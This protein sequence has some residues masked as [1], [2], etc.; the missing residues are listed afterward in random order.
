MALSE[1]EKLE[2]RYQENPQGLTFAPLAEAYR[3]SGD[4]QRAIDVLTPGLE[5]HPDYIP[6]SIVLGRCQL[7]LK[8][9][10]AAEAA[11]AHV[12][13]L[14]SENVIALKALADITE[15]GA[16]FGD[17]SR[18]LEQLL[19]VDRSNEEAREQLERVRASQSQQAVADEGAAAPGSADAGDAG[20]VAPLDGLEQT[21]VGEGAVEDDEF[22]ETLPPL[23]TVERETSGAAAVE[24][25][26]VEAFEPTA[27]AAPEPPPYS[28]PVADPSAVVLE[29]D[30]GVMQLGTSEEIVLSAAE[31]TEFQLP[32]ASEA[33]SADAVPD[34]SRSEASEYQLPSASEDMGGVPSAGAATGGS[35]YQL[36]SASEELVPE[37]DIASGASEFQLPDASSDFGGSALSMGDPSVASNEYQSADASAELLSPSLSADPVEEARA[38]EPAESLPPAVAAVFDADSDEDVEPGEWVT[39]SDAALDAGAAPFEQEVEA[40]EVSGS[41][42][43]TEVMEIVS[44][45]GDP[46]PPEAAAGPASEIAEPEMAA[47]AVGEPEVLAAGFV[48][49]EITETIAVVEPADVA[50]PDLVVT[51]SMAELFLKQ[52]HP[53][54]ALR[55][56]QELLSRRPDDTRLTDLVASLVASAPADEVLPPYAAS[57]S[58]GTSV[59]E[60]MRTV[61]GSR[62]NGLASAPP[63]VPANATGAPGTPTR[64]AGDHLTLSAIFGE[65][66]APMPPMSRKPRAASGPTAGRGGVSFDEFYGGGPAQ[67][68][69]TTR[70]A[71]ASHGAGGEDDLDQFHDWLQNLKR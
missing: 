30:L 61:L 52:G 53:A 41:L 71:G 14:D 3:K 58:G 42:A 70:P 43:I 40:E 50:E 56:Y 54:D 67:S 46:E 45:V 38:S 2:R 69:T 60:L 27:A 16:R 22:G 47:P 25:P 39:W 23:E 13:E 51:E 37:A 9:D 18:W 35:E 62:P 32:S 44:L 33:F 55:I 66:A 29:D 12:L 19:E 24:L 11:F 20:E 28:D 1:I 48:E 4:S 8:D 7:D 34:P 64:P 21:A 68:G 36:P 31:H 15:R 65:D 49:A 17:A 57:A 5:L 59:R 6:A 63:T 10:A 26:T